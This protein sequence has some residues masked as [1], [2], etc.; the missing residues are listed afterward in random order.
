MRREEKGRFDRKNIIRKLPGGIS[1]G[2]GFPL[3]LR[4]P[5]WYLKTYV[6]KL[7]NYLYGCTNKKGRRKP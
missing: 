2:G 4:R 1:A 7:I 6:M 5:I 3:A